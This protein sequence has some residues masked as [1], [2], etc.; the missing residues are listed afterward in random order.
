LGTMMRYINEQDK[1]ESVKDCIFTRF[2]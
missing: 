2:L 1:Y